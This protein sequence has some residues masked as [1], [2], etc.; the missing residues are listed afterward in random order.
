[1]TSEHGDQ[2]D[3]IRRLIEAHRLLLNNV[4][5]TLL[6]RGWAAADLE[7]GDNESLEFFWPPTA[8]VG[9]GGLPE[10]IHPSAEKRPGMFRPRRTPWNEPTIIRR[11][12]DKWVLNYGTA[13]AQK[14][15]A[16]QEYDAAKLFADLERIEWWPMSIEEARE[17]QAQRLFN[18][19][20]ADAYDQFSLGPSMQT[21]PYT[22]R[23]VELHDRLWPKKHL[24]RGDPGARKWAGDLRA[25]L[26]L[27]DAE[28]WTSAVRSARAGG[29]GWD[30]SGP[31]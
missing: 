25:R 6:S 13:I 2:P 30:T 10:W 1:M 12:R 24:L 17:L 3:E 7:V 9:Y 15:D 21:E 5:T 28:A 23:I 11:A 16:S 8:P 18:T 26:R 29:E 31:E 14:P 20:Y 4:E 19:T 22:S 27:V